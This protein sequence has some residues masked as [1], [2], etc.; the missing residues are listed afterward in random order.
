ML[1]SV[2]LV[3]VPSGT[4][5]ADVYSSANKPTNCPYEYGGMN[6]WCLEWVGYGGAQ[7]LGTYQV[8]ESLSTTTN[9]TIALPYPDNC[10]PTQNSYAALGPYVEDV[11]T[12]SY[13]NIS[14]K[15]GADYSDGVKV[16]LCNHGASKVVV[17]FPPVDSTAPAGTSVVDG[18]HFYVPGPE[19]VFIAVAMNSHVLT[20][21]T[22]AIEL[23]P[24]GYK[25]TQSSPLDVVLAG[26]KGSAPN[27]VTVTMT[28]TN[29]GS[30]TISGLRFTDPTGLENN[31]V[32]INGNNIGPTK[33]GLTLT[34]G[35]TPALPTTLPAN[36]PPV[37]IQYTYAVTSSGDAV[38]VANATGTDASGNSLT[39]KSALTVYVS[40][41][42][43]S[44]ADYQR[45]VTSALLAV[46]SITSE[47]LNTIANTEADHLAVGLNVPPA[48]PG[49][50]Y[51]AVQLG[52]PT[53]MGVLIGTSKKSDLDQWFSNYSATL[54]ADLKGGASYLGQSGQALATQLIQNITDPEARD[55]TLGRLVDGILALPSKTRAAL[56]SQSDNL[57]Y[58]GQALA[59]A[60]DGSGLKA[61]ASAAASALESLATNVG[62]AINGFTDAQVADAA[63]YRKNPT[64]YLNANSAH[65]ADAT[66]DL[67]KTE[68]ATV[69][70]D[71]I[72]K[73]VGAAAKAGFKALSSSAP[74][75]DAT[76][77]QVVESTA[78]PSTDST[79]ALMQ[80]ASI[81]TS[82]FQTLPVGTQL[83][84]NDAAQ[85]GGLVPGD[86]VGVQVAIDNTEKKFAKYGLKLQVGVRTSEPLSLGIDGS[87]KLTFMKPKA[88]SSM[89][90]TIGAPSQIAAYTPPGEAASGQVFQG[91]VV[92][93]FKPTPIPKA[94]LDAI[95]ETNP[96]YVTQYTERIKSQAGLWKDWENPNSTLRVLVQAS[97]D[98]PFVEGSTVNRVGVT[99]IESFPGFAVPPPPPGAQP[100][101][102]LQQLDQPEFVEKF[103]LTSDQA[104]ALKASLSKSPGAVQVNYLARPNPDGSVSFFDGLQN[105]QPW[106]SD[107]D[108]QDV[109]PADGAPWPAGVNPSQVQLEFKNQLQKNV[110]RLPN[111]GDSGSATDLPAQYIAAADKFV[112]S[113]ANPAFAQTIANNLAARYASQSRIFSS[114]AARL[115]AEAAGTSD[116]A[117]AKALL[118]LAKSYQATAAS[119]STVDA[120]YLMK[121]YPPGEKII[122]IKLGDVRVGYGQGS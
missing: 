10:V 77:A 106:V 57:G 32:L 11:T 63:A 49:Q 53:Q 44:E 61:T 76:V 84:V 116:P 91:G 14:D 35:P 46:D 104:Q 19:W 28:L 39:D 34:S 9:V 22:A 16:P 83:A 5:S 87:A 59:E 33:S 72:F 66:Y 25:Q 4:A 12:R 40:N 23:F 51:A 81:A 7:N 75:I 108:L 38:L 17:S 21:A 112:M 41:P 93:V 96:A 89:D 73:G 94:T 113:T 27:T 8:Y 79:A 119:F 30:S 64:G 71:G 60:H 78:P 15:Y 97:A 69:V 65:Y 115:T 86:Q 70:G 105:N 110:S 88:V 26:Q 90:M 98:S 3:V 29:N 1:L 48:S 120:A 62:Y 117:K 95:G 85:I 43:A 20:Y 121:T 13:V 101:L 74:A 47:G 56:A 80:N 54:A 111:H 50:Q 42:P 37:V 68:I 100:L 55:A 45:L 99:A 52:L 103:G 92:T 114:N 2:G 6:S 58:L 109:G 82:Q 31:G 24:P 67:I 118:T 102:Y 107:F 36:G 122:V 18:S